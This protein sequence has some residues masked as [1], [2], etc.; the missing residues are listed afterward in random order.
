MKVLVVEDTAEMQRSITRILE[1]RGFEPVIAENGLE[2]FARLGE[3]DFVAIVCDLALP[4]LQGNQFFS[5]IRDAYPDMA[6]RVVFV[7]GFATDATTKAFLEGTGQPYL[8]KPFEAA[9]LLA[10]VEAVTGGRA[11][12]P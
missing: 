4:F 5:Q 6:G 8:A 2:A 10:A 7:S 9:E 11:A 3:G 1:T 12:N